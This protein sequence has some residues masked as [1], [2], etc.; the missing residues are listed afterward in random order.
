LWL[1]YFIYH[2]RVVHFLI[3]L[4]D[5]NQLLVFMLVLANNLRSTYCACHS[6]LTGQSLHGSLNSFHKLCPVPSQP[7]QI[8]SG[9]LRCRH[10]LALFVHICSVNF[11]GLSSQ[12]YTINILK[13]HQLFIP[14]EPPGQPPTLLSILI[15][16]YPFLPL[17]NIL[18][19]LQ[20]LQYSFSH[21][22]TSISTYSLFYIIPYNYHILFLLFNNNIV[23]INYK[24][25]F[26][27]N[28]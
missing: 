11:A 24:P 8:I 28:R 10:E 18:Y 9:P 25:R 6:H 19:F 17:K 3:R 23:N 5:V 2:I 13:T 21:S 1:K 7:L 22:F 27:K 14:P 4:I 16:S 20:F 26:L 15:L 12:A